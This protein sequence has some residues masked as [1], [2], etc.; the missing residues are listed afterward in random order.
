MKKTAIQE[1]VEVMRRK[2]KECRKLA[3]LSAQDGD[4]H[5]KR[6]YASEASGY[7]FC[8]RYAESLLTKE[9]E[10]IEEAH[11]AGQGN[12]DVGDTIDW[13]KQW[14]EDYYKNHYSQTENKEG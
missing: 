6:L 13:K 1:L 9:R 2:I 3:M 11:L 12:G 8:L 14:A 4:N 7:E 5:S 10:I